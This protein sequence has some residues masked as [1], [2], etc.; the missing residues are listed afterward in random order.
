M[1]QVS[2]LDACTILLLLISLYSVYNILNF[3]Y[4]KLY[5]THFAYS[6]VSLEIHI[7]L[8]VEIWQ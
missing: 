7:K 5:T 1:E 2:I 3:E 4:I 8:N 6:N